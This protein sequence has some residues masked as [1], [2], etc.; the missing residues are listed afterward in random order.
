VALQTE[1]NSIVSGLHKPRGYAQGL[2]IEAGC[3]DGVNKLPCG[4][5]RRDRGAGKQLGARKI[6]T[7]CRG[8]GLNTDTREQSRKSTRWC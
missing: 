2:L 3:V 8:D 6:S 1:R 7:Y 4:V 5:K